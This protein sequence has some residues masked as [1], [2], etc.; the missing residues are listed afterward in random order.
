MHLT[1]YCKS[2]LPHE[3][4]ATGMWSGCPEE[5]VCTRARTAAGKS[6]EDA[7][8]R[9]TLYLLFWLRQNKVTSNC[10]KPGVESLAGLLVALLCVSGLRPG[11]FAWFQFSKVGADGLVQVGFEY[12]GLMETDR[13]ANTLRIYWLVPATSLRRSASLA[14]VRRNKAKITCLCLKRV[15]YF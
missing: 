14:H 1:S 15:F 5:A 11:A 13:Q 12:I 7:P 6:P 9:W 2:V 3:T 4:P 10:F 8:L